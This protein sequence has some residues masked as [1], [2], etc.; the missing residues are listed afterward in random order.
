MP[1]PDAADDV[2]GQVAPAYTRPNPTVPAT[3]TGT[4]RQRRGSSGTSA[5]ASA[6]ATAECPDTYPSPVARSR[7]RTSR[8]QVERSRRAATVLHHL[9]APVRALAR[10]QRRRGEARVAG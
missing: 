5:A 6:N 9:G 1:E 3:A 2:E 7:T 10:D 8:E 4:T